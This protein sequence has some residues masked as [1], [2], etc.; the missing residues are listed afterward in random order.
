M[1]GNGRIGHRED[2][3]FV[4]LLKFIK[5]LRV[6]TEIYGFLELQH[7]PFSTKEVRGSCESKSSPV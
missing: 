3:I 4:I 1:C 5:L 2:V 6:M 7:H